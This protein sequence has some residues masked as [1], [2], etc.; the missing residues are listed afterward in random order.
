[1]AHREAD[2]LASVAYRAFDELCQHDE[3]LRDF[4]LCQTA[5]L[6]ALKEAVPGFD[7]CYAKHYK[8]KEVDGTLEAFDSHVKE[9]QQL[10]ERFREIVA[11]QTSEQL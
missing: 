6:L 4:F 9:M 3:L 5:I 8:G 7:A 1:M 2:P 11:G 10:R